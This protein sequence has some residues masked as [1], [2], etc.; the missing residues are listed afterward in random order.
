MGGCESRLLARVPEPFTLRSDF[1]LCVT[2][3]D[4]TVQ[5][6]HPLRQSEISSF[7]VTGA[8]GRVR[9]LSATS[10]FEPVRSRSLHSAP[11]T[12][13]ASSKGHD[14]MVGWAETQAKGVAPVPV[15]QESGWNSW[16]YY[17]W[18]I[19]EDEVYKNA[20]LIASDP[21]L[22]RHVK[23]I[24]VDD[25]WQYCYG[26]WE[27]NSLFPSGMKKLARN[28]ARMGF[29][30]GLWFAPTIAE[31]HARLAQLH[32]EM[33]AAGASGFPCL[34]FSCMERKGF[35]L[36]PTHPGVRAWWDEL[37]RRYAGYG[38]RYFKLDF[39]AWTVRGRRFTNPKAGPGELM[40]HIID[41]IR[42]AV[43]PGS[44]ILGCNFNLDGGP[45][46]VDDVRVSS[47]IHSRWK[48]VKE[49]AC[50]VA[51]RFWAHERFWINDPD[52]A[53]CRGEE[54]SD[55][56]NLHQ[57]KAMLPF[58]RPEDTNPQG[59]DYLDSLVDLSQAEAEVLLSLVIAS[60]GAMN[61]SD[62]LPRLN[63]TG[64]RLLRKAVQAEKGAAAVPLDLFRSE[65]A[66]FWIQKLASGLHRVLLVNWT[67]RPA[68]RELDLGG[69]NVPTAGLVN[70]W[71]DASVPVK[72]GKVSAHLPPHSCL[73]IESKNRHSA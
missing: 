14:L 63:E 41:P 10:Y 53:L 60:G 43:G 39:L 25:G 54:T 65:L 13:T 18:T 31:P 57:L 72:A 19:T 6:S 26:E 47:D 34:G 69:L 3:G 35:V 67:D 11:V 21:V 23:R 50:A 38:Y 52:F 8:S 73:L 24:I 1:L 42:A 28:L 32:P 9:E 40:R 5:F 64:L 22:A 45:G 7:S 70:F 56:P 71:T 49:N 16:D 59:V 58:V 68:L 37:F 66:S 12:I 29:T 48:S 17:R 33:L 51:A 55:D 44:R 4:A 2:R 36:D 20:E 15:R 46:L 62:N 61:L 30:P 27:A